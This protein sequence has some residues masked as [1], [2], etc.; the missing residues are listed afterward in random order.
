MQ[1]DLPMADV[2]VAELGQLIAGPFC[3]QL[4]G[5]FGAEV[6][7]IEDPGRGDPM[8]QWGQATESGD[9][10]W[11]PVLARNKKSVTANLRTEAGQAVLRDLVQRCDVLIENFRPGTLER[12]GLGWPELSELNPRLVLVR[13][14]GYG[15]TGPY[16]ARPG[17][18]SIGEAMGGLR[19]VV[20]DPARPPSRLGVSI[21]DS[22]AGTMAALGAL[23]ALHHRSNTGVGQVVDS[24]IYEAVLAFTE[25]M[26][27]EYSVAGYVRERSGSTLPN[28]APSNVYPTVDGLMVIIAANGDQVFRRLAEAMQ[29]PELAVS[30]EYATHAARGARQVQLDELISGWTSSLNSSEVLKRCEEFAVPAGTIYRVPEMLDDPQYQARESIIDMPSDRFGK[31][32]M[33]N[34]VP[35]LSRTPGAVRWI[36]PDLGQHNDEILRGLLGLDDDLIERAQR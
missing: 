33:Q 15:Q 11:W 4:L 14:S 2:R 19:Y 28:I 24:A 26:V 30:A 25:S 20:G 8:R 13:V 16:A 29:R 32:K 34:V 1:T 5:D 35:R 12:W 18:G 21:G 3:G 10:L 7:K 17:F 22:L 36:G 23:V 27:S 31:L 6:I 9:S